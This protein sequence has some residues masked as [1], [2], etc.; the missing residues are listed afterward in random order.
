MAIVEGSLALKT[1]R[2]EYISYKLDIMISS[3]GIC[4]LFQ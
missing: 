3:D 1:T 2:I 4:L